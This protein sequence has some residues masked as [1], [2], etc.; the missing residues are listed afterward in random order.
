MCINVLYS[1]VQVE[2]IFMFISNLLIF[3]HSDYKCY[4]IMCIN[5][6]YSL[7]Q[8]EEI[9]MFIFMFIFNLLKLVFRF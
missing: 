7:V 6:L 3:V 5:V 1:L 2:E 4:K 8:V 9:F